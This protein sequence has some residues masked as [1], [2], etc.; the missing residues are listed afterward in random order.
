MALVLPAVVG[1]A[2]GSNAREGSGGEVRGRNGRGR[3]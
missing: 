2:Q 1:A 3:A